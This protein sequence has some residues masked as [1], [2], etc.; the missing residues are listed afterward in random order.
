MNPEESPQYSRGPQG[1]GLPEQLEVR[2]GARYMYVCVYIYIYSL[3]TTAWGLYMYT[4][5]YPKHNVAA[6][7]YDLPRAGKVG[8]QR[9]VQ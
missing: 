8:G 4:T 3:C 9:E 7:T 2:S 6:P 1:L 5:T